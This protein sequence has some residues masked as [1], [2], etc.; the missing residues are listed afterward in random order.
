MIEPRYL[1]KIVINSKYVG[2]FAGESVPLQ[3]KNW[4]GELWNIIHNI[5]RGIPY[6]YRNGSILK[7]IKKSCSKLESFW[8]LNSKEGQSVNLK[9][10]RRRVENAWRN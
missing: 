5:R 2:N 6:F 3:F 10:W 4:E 7:G 9:N 8:N 1:L